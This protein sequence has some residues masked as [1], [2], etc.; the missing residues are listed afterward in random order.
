VVPPDGILRVQVVAPADAVV[1]GTG[2]FI[3]VLTSDPTSAA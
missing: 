1:P 2:P 3:D